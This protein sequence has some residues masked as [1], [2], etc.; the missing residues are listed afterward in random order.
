MDGEGLLADD[1]AGH[2][3]HATG[4]D[5]DVRA[6][7]VSIL[8]RNV[9]GVTHTHEDETV[10]R[11]GR[12]RE[13]T[14]ARGQNVGHPSD[15]TRPPPHFDRATDQIADHVVQEPIGRDQ[16]AD[17][18]AAAEDVYGVHAADRRRIASRRRAERAEVVP[19]AHRRQRGAHGREIERA[20]HM[21]GN[22]TPQRVGDRAVV[23]Q[24]EVPLAGGR[25][26]R[27]ESRG[28]VRR[29]EHAHARWQRCVQR[30]L[31]GGGRQSRREG[32]RRGLA[33]CVDAR[34]GAAGAGHPHVGAEKAA[35]GVEDRTLDGG[36]V[37]LDLPA[38]EVAA[39]V[40][41]N[42][43][44][45]A[46]AY[47]GGRRRDPRSGIRVIQTTATRRNSPMPMMSFHSNRP[48]NESAVWRSSHV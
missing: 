1:V 36:R 24:I 43:T 5:G 10:G 47:R 3:A 2:F 17:E 7:R 25:A 16:H 31:D 11:R 34:V 41:E 33:Q 15:G 46:D 30:R 27:V 9:G 28:R 8:S 48:S 23:E 45:G 37:G 20:R 39:V 14:V 40:R 44:N 22:A 18:R 42:E 13:R 38:V 32:Q 35:C 12:T 21:P 26:T 19:A 6:H 4:P 29:I